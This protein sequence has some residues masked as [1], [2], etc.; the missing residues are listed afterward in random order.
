MIKSKLRKTPYG[1]SRTIE[2]NGHRYYIHKTNIKTYVVSSSI[3]LTFDSM[4]EVNG[5][6]HF[7]TIKETEEEFN[8]S[9]L[10]S[11][12]DRENAQ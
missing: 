5:E 7:R 11:K 4:V 10:V 2:G 6:F 12:K 9:N 1:N 8:K 3:V